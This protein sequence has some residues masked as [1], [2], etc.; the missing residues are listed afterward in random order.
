MT[1]DLLAERDAAYH[2]IP[3]FIATIPFTIHYPHIGHTSCPLGV[4]REM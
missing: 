3:L 1:G 2:I 4:D